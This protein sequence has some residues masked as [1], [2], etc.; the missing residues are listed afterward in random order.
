MLL[1][2]HFSLLFQEEKRG[3]E[4]EKG[5][6]KMFTLFDSTNFVNIENP[7]EERYED[8]RHRE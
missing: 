8:E 7:A 4:K 1:I 6:H 3:K 2:L 5:E